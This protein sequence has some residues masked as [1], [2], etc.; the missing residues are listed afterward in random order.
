MA[1]TAVYVSPL[2]AQDQ[3]KVVV[4]VPAK[5]PA[6]A[7]GSPATAEDG[8]YQAL[9]TGLQQTRSVERYMVDRLLDGGTRA[10]LVCSSIPR[11]DIS[12]VPNWQP[13]P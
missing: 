2:A 1:P 8:K 11:A 6:L 3:H 7:I 5:G 10:F 9:V 4:A 12:M 13:R